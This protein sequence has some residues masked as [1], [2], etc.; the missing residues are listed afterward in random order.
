[1]AMCLSL[2]KFPIVG[3]ESSRRELF[4]IPYF[5]FDGV[6]GEFLITA[7]MA[8]LRPK[9]YPILGIYPLSFLRGNF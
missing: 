5:N 2:N 4:P 6:H 3:L 9:F 1:M 7:T 8:L